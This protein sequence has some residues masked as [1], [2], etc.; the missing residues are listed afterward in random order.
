MRRFAALLPVMLLSGCAYTAQY[1]PS[2]INEEAWRLQPTIPGSVVVVTDPADDMKVYSQHPS[3]WTGAA[4]TFRA[5]LGES[6]REVTLAVLSRR[7]KGGAQHSPEVPSGSDDRV[8]VKPR[9]S[10]FEY[11]YNQLKNLG[12]MITPEAKVSIGVSLY[13]PSGET[14]MEKTYESDYVTG[15]SYVISSRPPEK[16]NKAVHEALYQLVWQ[17]T[18]DIEEQLTT[19]NSI[20]KEGR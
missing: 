10:T 7:F 2:Y 16:V 6:L 13:A 3:S 18:K 12:L 14:L 19:G 8:I 15:G 1:K 4:T 17:M 11:R 9:M 5:K 20:D